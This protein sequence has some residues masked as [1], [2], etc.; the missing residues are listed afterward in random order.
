MKG[1]DVGSGVLYDLVKSKILLNP[2]CKL[3]FNSLNK[4]CKTKD[5][6]PQSVNALSRNTANASP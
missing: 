1:S 6:L 4:S 5:C 3:H 2:N